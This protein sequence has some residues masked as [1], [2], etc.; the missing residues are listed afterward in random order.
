MA[1]KLDAREYEAEL[2]KVLDGDTIDCYI[3]LGFNLKTKKRIR[4]MGIDTWESRTRDLDEKK[5]GLAAKARNK[6]LL[7]SGRFK[8]KSFG[9]GKFGRVLGEIFV[10]P[11]YVGEHITECIGNPDS[12]IDLSSDGWVSINDILI[13]EGHAYDYHG[14][15]KKDF[16]AEAAKEIKKEKENSV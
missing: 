16:K 15:K 9:T 1:K 4:Y 6:E 14:E 12:T 7:E 13:E 10:S 2:I 3:D 11:E 8:L 5:K